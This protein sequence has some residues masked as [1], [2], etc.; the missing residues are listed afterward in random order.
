MVGQKI[1]E[2]IVKNLIFRQFTSFSGR[3]RLRNASKCKTHVQG[4]HSYCFWSFR[5]VHAYPDLFYYPGLLCFYCQHVH[6]PSGVREAVSAQ[7]IRTRPSTRFQILSGFKTSHS[8]CCRRRPSL[9]CLVT[10]RHAFPKEGLVYFNEFLGL[11]VSRKSRK[12][13]CEIANRLFWKADLLTCFKE[14]KRK[15]TMKFDELN[16]LR[17]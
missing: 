15:I 14:T 5:P 16:A 17:S 1:S 4:V 3:G 9:S 11:F 10:F 8:L 7:S 12:A 6:A 13:I 2:F